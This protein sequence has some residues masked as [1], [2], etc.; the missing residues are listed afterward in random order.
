M[1]SLFAPT[2]QSFLLT[3]EILVVV[4]YFNFPTI[5]WPTLQGSCLNSTLPCD[6]IFCNLLQLVEEPT[7]AMEGIL[8]LYSTHK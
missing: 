1:C 5:H 6:T 3:F 2:R 7:H 4:G 8:D